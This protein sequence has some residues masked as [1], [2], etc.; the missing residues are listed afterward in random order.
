MPADCLTRI[1]KE[2]GFNEDAVEQIILEKKMGSQC[3]V[4]PGELMCAVVT[5]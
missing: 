1:C 4:V 5:V 3:Q 2:E